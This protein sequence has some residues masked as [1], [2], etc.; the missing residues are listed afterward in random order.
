MEEN[1]DSNTGCAI[2]IAIVI[3]A[4]L[5]FYFATTDKSELAEGGATISTII[6][7][8]VAYF[9]IKAYNQKTEDSDS[10][11]VRVAV[12][13]GI[14]IALLVIF[15]FAVNDFALM[16]GIGSI[17]VIALAIAVG[18]WMYRSKDD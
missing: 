13:I 18:V 10:K 12:P 6:F 15:G 5:M 17:F 1:K 7:F 9:V 3:I 16:V 4:S 2:I 14:F 11:L 8:V